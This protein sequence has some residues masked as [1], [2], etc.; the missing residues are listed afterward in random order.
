MQRF[1]S[2]G[3]R[4]YVRTDEP[5]A[6]WKLVCTCEAQV[7]Y[8]AQYVALFVKTLLETREVR[9]GAIPLFNNRAV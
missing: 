3:P 2:V 5:K 6:G 4:V 9:Q 8:E 1:K 7:H